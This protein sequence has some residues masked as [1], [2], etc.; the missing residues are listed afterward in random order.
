M[1]AAK[2]QWALDRQKPEDAVPTAADLKPYLAGGKLP[3]CPEGGN[4]ALGP[5]TQKP[6]CSQPGHELPADNN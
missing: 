3:A 1:D 5:L 2:Q 6:R 4:Y